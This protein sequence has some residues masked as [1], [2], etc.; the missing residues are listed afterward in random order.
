MQKAGGRCP[1]GSSKLPKASLRGAESCESCS[2]VFLTQEGGMAVG[3]QWRGDSLA[4]ANFT[5]RLR[6]SFS[7]IV[8]GIINLDLKTRALFKYPFWGQQS[9]RES[10]RTG[11]DFGICEWLTWWLWAH[12]GGHKVRMTE[13]EV[14]WGLMAGHFPTHVTSDS[15]CHFFFSRSKE[16]RNLGWRLSIAG[17]P[18]ASHFISLLFTWKWG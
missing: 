9:R 13:N 18:W 10:W 15:Y 3:S 17:W 4:M 1:C 6:L 11:F 2:A 7:S 14:L 12:M 8:D 5:F 16:P